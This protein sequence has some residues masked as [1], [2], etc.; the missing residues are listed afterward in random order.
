M[1]CRELSFGDGCVAFKVFAEVNRKSQAE[2]SKIACSVLLQMINTAERSGALTL[3]NIRVC[4]CIG[5]QCMCGCVQ[6]E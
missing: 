1:D 4:V 6:V 5:V 3:S 2:H